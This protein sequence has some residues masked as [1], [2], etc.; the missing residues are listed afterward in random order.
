MWNELV[1]VCAKV[2]VFLMQVHIG[3][4]AG[5]WVQLESEALHILLLIRDA[6]LYLYVFSYP[7][8]SPSACNEVD[9]LNTGLPFLIHKKYI[10]THLYSN[11]VDLWMLTP[12]FAVCYDDFDKGTEDVLLNMMKFCWETFCGGPGPNETGSPTAWESQ[13]LNS[14]FLTPRWPSG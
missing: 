4:A 10:H 12:S 3:P 8:V 11:F 6:W 14:S 5:L 2:T 13:E 1:W 9:W 7:S